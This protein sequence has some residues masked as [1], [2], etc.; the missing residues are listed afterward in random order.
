[1]KSISNSKLQKFKNIILLSF[2]LLLLGCESKE[3]VSDSNKNALNLILEN[4]DVTYTWGCFFNRYDI[5]IYGLNNE[6]KVN[7]FLKNLNNIKKLNDVNIK[8][9]AYKDNQEFECKEYDNG[10]KNCKLKLKD[11]PFIN[12]KINNL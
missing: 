11:K 7:L 2:T 5:N 4:L 10:A 6:A 3:C 8:I 12:I 1:M 9:K